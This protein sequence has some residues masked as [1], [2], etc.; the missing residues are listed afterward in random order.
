M[1]LAAL[2]EQAAKFLERFRTEV[3]EVLPNLIGA[4]VLIL[5]GWVVAKALKALAQR[6]V[7]GLDKVIPGDIVQTELQRPQMSRPAS[8]MVSALVF[9][10]VFFLFIAAATETL[11]LPGLSAWLGGIAAYLPRMLAAA[12][13]AFAGLIAGRLAR[14]GATRAATTAGSPHAHT[15]GRTVQVVIVIATVVV[16]ANQIGLDISFVTTL[17]IILFA[18]VLAGAALAF[19]LGSRTAVSNILACHHAQRVYQ[20]GQTVRIGAQEGRIARF[21]PTSVVLDCV[22][23]EVLIPAQRFSEETSL[24]VSTRG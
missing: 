23:G 15:L 24:L 12:L 2:L 4:V 11:G 9:W 3:I 5:V 21:T 20:I 6:V 7:Q 14:E 16:C 19:G 8:N 22:D 13:V 10:I 1:S 17:A 18:S